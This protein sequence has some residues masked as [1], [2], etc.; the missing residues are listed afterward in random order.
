M[1]QNIKNL[2]LAQAVHNE[3][4]CDFLNS[5]SK[6]YD[7]TV[8]S[9]FYAALH[10]VSAVMFPVHYFHGKNAGQANTIGQYCDLLG[11]KDSK[12]KVMTDLV[13]EKCKGIG[14]AYKALLE[15]SYSSR[16]ERGCQ[17]SLFAIRARRYLSQ[18]KAHCTE[19]SSQIP[20]QNTIIVPA[21]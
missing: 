8:T 15:F 12:H 18:I 14:N 17:D 2:H 9:A 6:F 11:I 1:S 3:S 20:I 4:A 21:E 7:W 5:N 19:V 13:Y 16:Y 10:Y